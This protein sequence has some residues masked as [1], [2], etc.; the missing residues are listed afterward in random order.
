MCAIYVLT[1]CTINVSSLPPENIF[2][3]SLLNPRQKILLW[4]CFS[5][6]RGSERS[7]IAVSRRQS[8]TRRSSPPEIE[9]HTIVLKPKV[10]HIS[11]LKDKSNF[12]LENMSVWLKYE[13]FISL[14]ENQNHI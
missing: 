5:I 10:I 2:V 11:I 7:A 1:S 8:K 13:I 9:R 3:L 4:C 12:K 6:A 14:K